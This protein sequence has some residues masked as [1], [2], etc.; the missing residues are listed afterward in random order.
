MAGLFLGLVRRALEAEPSAESLLKLLQLADPDLTL[1][2]IKVKADRDRIFKQLRLAIHPDRQDAR[3]DAT[4]VFQQMTIFYDLCANVDF[5]PSNRDSSEATSQHTFPCEFNVLERWTTAAENIKWFGKNAK[6]SKS[7]C[8]NLRGHIV[9]HAL[10]GRNAG[11]AYDLDHGRWFHKLPGNSTE[12]VKRELMSNGPVLSASFWPSRALTQQHGLLAPSV[13]LHAV[14]FGWRLRN[15]LGAVW[16]VRAKGK[17][18]EV[19]LDTCCLLHNVQIPDDQR[20]LEWQDLATYPYLEKD[21]SGRDWLTYTTCNVN[22]TSAQVASLR[23]LGGEE[24][25]AG[26]V[27]GRKIEVCQKGIKVMSRRAEITD[28]VLK[29]HKPGAV[30]LRINFL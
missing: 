1:Q 13:A 29:W 2:D 6:Q 14:I 20:D 17:T 27:L 30:T 24:L 23:T 15:G 21:F 12:S 25:C 18:L 16:L 7:W 11:W 19:P 26:S 3:D 5:S 4:A 22:F 28:L 8:Y 10:T 9:H